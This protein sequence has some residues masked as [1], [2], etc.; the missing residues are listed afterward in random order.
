MKSSTSGAAKLKCASSRPLTTRRPCGETLPTPAHQ[1]GR[2]SGSK[3]MRSTILKGAAGLAAAALLC[4]APANAGGCWRPEGAVA[5]KVRDLH[6]RLM[7]ATLRCR[8]IGAD[9]EGA[10]GNFVR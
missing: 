6:S 7:V 8:A 4:A 3:G 9:I 5:A 2:E 1:T 10:Y